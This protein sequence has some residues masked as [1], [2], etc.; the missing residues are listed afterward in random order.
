MGTAGS[1]AVDNK[2]GGGP[3]EV[4]TQTSTNKLSNSSTVNCAVKIVTAGPESE[5]GKTVVKTI[6][7]TLIDN[8]TTAKALKAVVAD[9]KKVLKQPIKKKGLTQSDV[10]FRKRQAESLN[11]QYGVAGGNVQC[12]SDD[13]DE[14]RRRKQGLKIKG[15]NSKY[16][17]ASLTLV[18][19][20]EAQR[21]L[22]PARKERD[23]HDLEYD[24]G[25]CK[26]KVKKKVG[27]IKNYKSWKS[28][29]SYRD[30]DTMAAF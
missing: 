28:N 27:P 4:Q 8:D 18:D 21:E 13:E 11:S 5:S 9:L 29:N 1:T 2:F 6:T 30:T 23:F 24:Q 19:F 12:W 14:D 25:R 16:C 3:G 15:P 26:H 22:Q 10:N 7:T 17:A 20:R